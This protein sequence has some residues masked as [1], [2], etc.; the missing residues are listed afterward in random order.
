LEKRQIEQIKR[1]AADQ[2]FQPEINT[3]VQNSGLVIG[4]ESVELFEAAGMGIT[5]TLIPTGVG[6]RLYKNMFSKSNIMDI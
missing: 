6:T 5:T 3:S 1:M 2:G 4:V